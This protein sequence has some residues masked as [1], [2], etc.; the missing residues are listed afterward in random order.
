MWQKD[1]L[2]EFIKPPR[3]AAFQLSKYARFNN[4]EGDSF[5]A[6]NPFAV[7]DT[8]NDCRPL[9]FQKR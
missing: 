4:D 5:R 8:G 6:Q 3:T 9:A 7:M 2:A 1:L